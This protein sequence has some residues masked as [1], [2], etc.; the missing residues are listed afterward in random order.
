MLLQW[1]GAES[2][3][4]LIM[5]NLKLLPDEFEKIRTTL[6]ALRE[7]FDARS[8]ALISRSGQELAFESQNESTTD[9]QALASL[10]AS[11]L[12]ATITL[13]GLVGEE[14]F[15]RMYHRG[16]QVSL[17]MCPTGEEALLLLV[18]DSLS[19]QRFPARRLDRAVL[20]LRDLLE[21]EDAVSGT[22]SG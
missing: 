18:L 12:A 11:T 21:S 15:H 20:V 17:I 19:R 9:R 22:S 5:A 3:G 4:D 6:R 13:A 2:S 7:A 8:V 16:E 1:P 14:R 10:A